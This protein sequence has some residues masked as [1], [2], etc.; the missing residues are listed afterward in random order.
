MIGQAN[1]VQGSRMG[2]DDARSSTALDV[3]CG[4]DN[5]DDEGI[6]GKMRKERKVDPRSSCQ[7]L[8]CAAVRGSSLL[9]SS[10]DASPMGRSGT[11]FAQS[12][13]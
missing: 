3:R 5:V 9:T 4:D 13:S 12:E 10:R 2:I 1:A 11:N 6:D 8:C 7:A